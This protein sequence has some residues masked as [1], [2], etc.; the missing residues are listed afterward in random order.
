[1]TTNKADLKIVKTGSTAGVG[2]MW[3]AKAEL[4]RIL[5]AVYKAPDNSMNKNPLKVEINWVEVRRIED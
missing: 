2:N 4:K 5:N 1:M 3:D